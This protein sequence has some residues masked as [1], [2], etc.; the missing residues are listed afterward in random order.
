MS[1]R[2]LGSRLWRLPHAAA[3]TQPCGKSRSRQALF[4]YATPC[5]A[6][7]VW[8]IARSALERQLEDRSLA[9]LVGAVRKKRAAAAKRVRRA[10]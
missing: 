2:E 9:D 6:H 10:G 5:P 7:P 4:P 8:K 3:L 1:S